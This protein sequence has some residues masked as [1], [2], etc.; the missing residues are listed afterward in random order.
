M[1]KSLLHSAGRRLAFLGVFIGAATALAAQSSSTV[2]PVFTS[3]PT[4]IST[5]APAY[6]LSYTASATETEDVVLSDLA[7]ATGSTGLTALTSLNLVVTSGGAIVPGLTTGTTAT[8]SAAGTVS[9]AA[10]S[11]TTYQIFVVGVPD[12]TS[13]NSNAIS[14]AVQSHQTSASVAY[15]THSFSA[16]STALPSS[17]YYAPTPFSIA[18]AGDYVVTLTDQAAPAPMTT[19]LAFV[20][21]DAAGSTG[22]VVPAG[23]PVTLH[24]LTVGTYKIYVYAVAD[25]TV[26]AGLF[27]LNISQA[28]GSALLDTSIPV[29]LQTLATSL[30]TSSAQSLT[31]SATDLAEPAPLTTLAAAVTSGSTLLGQATAGQSAA[32]SAPKGTLQIWQV[33]TP[34]AGSAGAFIVSLAPASGNALYAPLSIARDPA[35]TVYPYLVTPVAAGSYT[36]GL[37]DLNFPASFTTLSYQVYQGGSVIGQGSAGASLPAV[38]A[39]AGTLLIVVTAVPKSTD[40][41][42]SVSL[43]AAGASAPQFAQV[44]SI[45]PNL[46]GVPFVIATTGSYDVTVNDLGWP[47]PFASLNGLITQ[48]GAKQGTIYGGGTQ[49]GLSL[50]AGNYVITI[51]GTP[52]ALQTAG[53]YTLAVTPAAPVVTLSASPTSVPT[54]TGTRLT[55]TSTGATA[56]SASATGPTPTS[57][58]FTGTQATSGSD[59]EGPFTTAGTVVYTLNCTG[60]GG[61]ASAMATVTVTAGS[62]SGGSSSG[63]GGA[64]G[65]LGLG[66][67]AALAALR[68]RG[69]SA[70]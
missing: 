29:G 28:G 6:T 54:S 7:Q 32:I 42:Y 37:S 4:A 33:T 27:G 69:A 47:A 24:G 13:S 62:S 8:L 48:A 2:T 45:G 17:V 19:L 14:V 41:V 16:S 38:T 30:A 9:F 22:L 11:G 5:G 21:S 44:E 43:T 3:G 60:P 67:I 68:R 50:G 46:I 64:F 49:A 34:A 56:C 18:T 23:S 58:T 35:G 40:G 65:L 31:L 63:G 39:Q 61:S 12:A 1:L 53:L 26:Q 15:G 70:R 52:A 36:P 51:N 66:A 57:T 10:T 20:K 25:A 55:W 59:S